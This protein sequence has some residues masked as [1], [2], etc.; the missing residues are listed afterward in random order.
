MLHGIRKGEKKDGTYFR[1]DSMS[2][3]YC[4]DLGDSTA[5]YVKPGDVINLSSNEIILNKCLLNGSC[6]ITEIDKKRIEKELKDISVA[7][8]TKEAQNIF[9][10]LVTKTN[11]EI[12]AIAKSWNS[13][14][15]AMI[16]KE[17]CVKMDKPYS[18]ILQIEEIANN[19]K[20][21]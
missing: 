13:K 10:E 16:L 2:D 15:K 12:I 21:R 7:T 17:K 3:S 1:N 19:S 14:Q 18:L 11:A 4:F 20:G 8:E 9:D 5:A 6:M